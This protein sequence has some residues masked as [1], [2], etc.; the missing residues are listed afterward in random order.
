MDLTAVALA[1]TDP[2]LGGRVRAAIRM[3][4]TQHSTTDPVGDASY[5]L[6]R[7]ILERDFEAPGL[8][9][10]VLA[11]DQVTDAVALDLEGQLDVSGLTDAAIAAAVE[12]H[13]PLSV[14]RTV[15]PL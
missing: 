10:A 15:L 2:A 3:C 8:R 1:E 9:S 4:A 5:S 7:A 14:S 11:S 12:E 6:A 13:W